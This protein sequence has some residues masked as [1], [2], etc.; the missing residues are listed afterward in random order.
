MNLKLDLQWIFF[1]LGETLIDESAAIKES[2]RQFVEESARLG[3]SFQPA[4]AEQGM[5]DAYRAFAEHPMRAFMETSIPSDEH[6]QLI[7]QGMK[8]RKDFE[9]PFPAA[10]P[11]VRQLSQLYHIGVIANQGIG[12]AAR[13]EAY[14]LSPYISV[15][16]SSAEAGVAKPD[17][18]LYQLALE[19]ASCLPEHALMIGDRIDNDI[20][21]AKRLGMKAVY[22]RQGFAKYQAVPAGSDAPDAIIDNIEEI[23]D[24]LL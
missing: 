9:R 23:L 12:T 6:R 22:V 15:C 14:G 8:Y 13:L 11:I 20:I 19:Q 4:D 2:I 7:R 10:L 16:C 3:Y 24:L 1:D 5:E 18:R 21:P 17:P